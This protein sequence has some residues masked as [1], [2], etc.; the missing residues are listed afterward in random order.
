MAEARKLKKE[1]KNIKRL[2]DTNAYQVWKFRL[3]LALRAQ[4][5]Y[6]YVVISPSEDS[7]TKKKWVDKDIEIQ[8]YNSRNWPI[9]NL[10]GN[11]SF[12]QDISA[13]LKKSEMHNYLSGR[14][15][16]SYKK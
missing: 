7:K 1:I 15:W 10:V 9:L 5:L 14:R 6:E 13:G 12:L 3:S 11:K 16:E 2:N 4:G 8:K